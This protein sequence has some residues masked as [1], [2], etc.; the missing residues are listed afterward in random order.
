MKKLKNLLNS[1]LGSILV[2]VICFAPT[3]AYL[4]AKYLLES[5]GFWQNLFLAGVAVWIGGVF[6]FFL[7]LF[8]LALIAFVWSPRFRYRSIYRANP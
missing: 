5:K 2:T 4:F 6:Q 1:F 8:W 3:E 7:F